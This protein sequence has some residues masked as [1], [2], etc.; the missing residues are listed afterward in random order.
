MVKISK[1]VN[2]EQS[3]KTAARMADINKDSEFVNG[4]PFGAVIVHKDTGTVVVG[5]TNSVLKNNDPTAHAE[6]VAIRQACEHLGTHDLSDYVLVTSC[7][8]CPMCLSAAIWANITNIYYGNTQFDAAEIGFRDDHIYK[9]IHALEDEPKTPKQLVEG[10]LIQQVG[11]EHTI[12]TFEAFQEQ[13]DKT[14][15]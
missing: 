9:L 10:I 15:Y 13:E 6:V 3:M 4:G 5:G 1:N 2:L 12:G 11:R 8:P 7:Y 14:V